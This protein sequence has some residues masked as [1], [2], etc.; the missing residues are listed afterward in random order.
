MTNDK[1]IGKL[2]LLLSKKLGMQ[3]SKLP[4]VLP[5]AIQRTARPNKAQSITFL[6][7]EVP[8]DV[9]RSMETIGQR[10]H[11]QGSR[12]TDIIALREAIHRDAD[13]HV[14]MLNGIIR[15]AK[16]LRTED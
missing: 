1:N 7:R 12:H 2:C 8:V 10:V 5:D 16:L 14:S 4:F 13:M 11:Q 3:L 15:K 9:R 6:L